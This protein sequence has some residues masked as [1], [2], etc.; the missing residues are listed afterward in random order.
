MT[1]ARPL[2]LAVVGAGRVASAVYLPLV[3]LMPELFRLTAIV[4]TDPRRAADLRAE[5]PGTVVCADIDLAVLAGAEA[6]VCATPWPTHAG[7][8]RA[9]VERGLPVLCEK[10]VTLDPS[11]LDDLIDAERRYGTQVAVGYMKRHDPAVAWFV[12]AV[13]EVLDDLR[14]LIVTVVDPNAPHQVAHRLAAPLAPTPA[15]RLAADD[16]VR[17]IVGDTYT[18]E[19]RTAYAHGLGGSLIHHVNLVHAA[20]AG[21]QRELAGNLGYARHWAEGTAVACGWWP[22][23]DLGVQMSHVRVPR[24]RDYSE[25][26]VAVAEERKLTLQLP[27]PYLLDRT[28]TVTDQTGDSVR[29]VCTPPPEHNGFVR[30]LRAWARSVRD[31]GAPALPGLAEA[32]ADLRVVREAADLSTAPDRDE[33]RV[34]VR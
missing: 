22:S 17:G 7:I 16:T 28:A 10:P 3:R 4:E 14:H 9:A 6:V 18:P 27:S 32:K 24:H 33:S 1:S 19:R 30:Q 8:V 15:T 23:G 2:P 11:D 34:G 31:P 20:L 5:F 21:S 29:L 25:T 26:V 12:D 13:S